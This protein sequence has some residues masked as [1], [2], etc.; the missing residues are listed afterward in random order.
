MV[1]PNDISF[2]I[3]LVGDENA[4]KSAFRACTTQLLPIRPDVGPSVAST[5]HPYTS[6]IRGGGRMQLDV[7]DFGP[8]GERELCLVRKTIASSMFVVFVDLSIVKQKVDKGIFSG[9]T[10]T[11]IMHHSVKETI[12]KWVNLSYLA[13]PH[14]CPVMLVGTHK[15]VLSVQDEPALL[16]VLKELRAVATQAADA[17]S[18]S[19]AAV[20]R[21][22]DG[23]GAAVVAASPPRCFG[24]YAV[25]CVDHTVTSE[26]P[27]DGPKTIKQLWQF[28]CELGPKLADRATQ[29]PAELCLRSSLALLKLE[30][31]LRA[32]SLHDLFL[33][34]LTQGIAE[35][36]MRTALRRR[37]MLGELSLSTLRRTGSGGGM[38]TA[39]LTAAAVPDAFHSMPSK[40]ALAIIDLNGM[41]R[42]L[43]SF[44]LLRRRVAAVAGA[45]ESAPSSDAAYQAALRRQQQQQAGAGEQSAFTG[46]NDPFA[47]AASAASL[48]VGAAAAAATDKEQA[49]ANAKAMQQLL[50]QLP[51]TGEEKGDD[52]LFQMI[53]EILVKHLPAERRDEM[54]TRGVVSW[55]VLRDV[56]AP[57]FISGKAVTTDE[58]AALLWQMVICSG[59]VVPCV[60]TLPVADCLLLLEQELEAASKHSSARAALQGSSSTADDEARQRRQMQ[61]HYF[62]FTLP[63]RNA[64]YSST[65]AQ[66]RRA[67]PREAVEQ[68]T[69]AED[70]ASRK[71]F[72]PRFHFAVRRCVFDSEF[73]F[74]SPGQ[75]FALFAGRLVNTAN[76]CVLCPDHVYESGAWLRDRNNPRA[77]RLLVSADS[78]S[79][80]SFRFVSCAELPLRAH[81]AFMI[82]VTQ[83]VR[84]VFDEFELARLARWVCDGPNAFVTPSEHFASGPED[85]SRLDLAFGTF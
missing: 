29:T 36:A 43:S 50:S 83:A 61:Q 68:I 37:R 51:K 45:S 73:S 18:K 1:A 46:G 58:K 53:D 39:A 32:V 72:P 56:L 81:A 85:L 8:T 42:L 76:V 71:M 75:L 16:A 3:C 15:D 47:G 64:P 30:R 10:D 22:P 44:D 77:S 62:I 60:S 52:R 54:H 70:A 35:T 59:Y 78:R 11:V 55:D 79:E 48:L 80:I 34:S 67:P 27:R 31:G 84:A 5:C 57:V 69:P 38:M 14:G 13:N 66:R 19:A 40:V 25:S 4:G 26:N 2:R 21:A 7:I 24:C 23:T 28:M 63:V 33:F 20:V 82:E 17:L 9:R 74:S 12:K 41:S 6:R 49:A 65:A